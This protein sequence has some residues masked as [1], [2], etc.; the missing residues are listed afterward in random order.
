MPI[1]PTTPRATQLTRR[2]HQVAELV[3][4]GLSNRDIAKRLFLSERTV[5][6]HIEQIL[7]RLGFTSRSEIAAWVG[8]TQAGAAV[9]VPGAT[10]RGN[11]PAPLTS[12]VGR[13][14]EMTA[15]RDLVIAN[16]LVTVTGPGGTGKTRLALALAEMLEPTYADGAWLCDLAPL[17]DPTLVASTVAETLGLPK[18]TADLFAAARRNRGDISALL[19]LDNCEHVLPAASSV[20]EIVLAA[21]RGLRI[22]ATSMAPLGLPGE[23]VWRLDPLPEEDAVRFFSARAHAATPG[24]HLDDATLPAVQSI[25]RQLEGLPLALELAAPRLRVLTLQELADT[26]FDSTPPTRS[27]GRHATLEAVAEWGYRAL[28][29]DERELFRRLG[30][31]AGWFE[32]EDATAIAQTLPGV[33][34]LVRS[35]HEKSMVI[36]TRARGTTRFRLLETLKAFARTQLSSTG[37]LDDTRLAHGE[38]MAALADLWARGYKESGTWLAPKIA[39]MVDDMRAAITTLL[40]LRPRQAAR[41][42]AALLAF[43]NGSGRMSEGLHL[44]VRVNAAVPEPCVERCWLLYTQASLL[45]LLSRRGDA[46]LA[47]SEAN[48]LINLPECETM[49]PYLL[50]LR[51]EIEGAIGD[52]QKAESLFREAIDQY[53]T[54]G[55]LIEVAH[56]LNSLAMLLLGEGRYEEA[57][58]CAERSAALLPGRPFLRQAALDTLGQ[59]CSFLG[60]LDRAR[61]CWLEAATFALECGAWNFLASSLEGLSFTASGRGRNET[62][63]RL[64]YCALH[65]FERIDSHYAEPLASRLDQMIARV[66]QELEPEL[67]RL[68][69]QGR[70]LSAE[71]AIQLAEAEG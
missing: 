2:G 65:V 53:T 32:V 17:A 1:G 26:I 12:F 40:E 11:L 4:Q 30:V 31:F 46:E 20:A 43:W 42:T 71:D 15:L 19:V 58:V 70:E 21:C 41:L 34:A 38:R 67:S 27:G 37:E 8:R 64:H 47:L 66:E 5:E 45:L 10:H 52:G 24:F 35:L 3:A 33:P 69:T 39:E 22:L 49:R 63:L 54:R 36:A 25:C 14:T 61:E 57:R 7:N 55:Q 50:L 29:R 56:P 62:A 13:D 23:A 6:W 59:A 9:R 60:S 44:M 48:S 51:G 16:R 28:E 68:R 18:E